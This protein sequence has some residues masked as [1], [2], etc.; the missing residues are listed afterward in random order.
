MDFRNA[1]LL[2]VAPGRQPAL[3]QNFVFYLPIITEKDHQ[4][5]YIW[6]AC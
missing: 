1:P 4:A 2:T 6:Y 5:T 3:K